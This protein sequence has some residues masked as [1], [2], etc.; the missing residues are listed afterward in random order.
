M[1]T[2]GTVN[3]SNETEKFNY[4]T[5]LFFGMNPEKRLWMLLMFYLAKERALRVIDNYQGH[6]DGGFS[7][8][9]FLHIDDITDNKVI[10]SWLD[11]G[12][13]N[14]A[15]IAEAPNHINFDELAYAI[16]VDSHNYM[17]NSVTC[18]HGIFAKNR[19]E[20]Q[21]LM[22]VADILISLSDDWYKEN[23]KW[24]FDALIRRIHNQYGK[25]SS[26]YTQP[27]ELTEIV[28]KI[29]SA[30]EGEVYNPYAGVC[31]Y[32]TI[33][34]DNCSYLGQEVFPISNAIGK[35]NLLVNDRKNAILEQCTGETYWRA[36]NHQFDYI[37][38]TP[39]FGL[40]IPESSYRTADLQFL[41]ESS[42]CTRH[43]SVGVYPA[44]ICNHRDPNKNEV[45]RRLIEEDILETVILLPSGVFPT[46]NIA[47]VL[48][49]VNK[50]KPN[51]G[52]VRFVDASGC[53]TKSGRYNILDVNSIVKK[54]EESFPMNDVAD[55][56]LDVLRSNSYRV[57]PQFY[58]SYIN[59][60]CPEGFK[61]VELSDV[62]TPIDTQ[63]I[64]DCESRIYKPNING[65]KPHGDIVKA[66][67]LPVEQIE[68]TAY[69]SVSEDAFIVRL[70]GVFHVSYLLAE[71]MSVAINRNYK[72]YSID[73]SHAYYQYILTE[74]SKEYFS[75]QL[76]KHSISGAISCIDEG[77]FL[78]LRIIIPNDY[79]EQIRLSCES[80]DSD[81]QAHINQ[82]SQKYQNKIDRVD[83]NQRQRKHAVAQ[84]L[85][86]ML[87]LVENVEDY[88]LENGAITKD[89]IV[90]HRFGT[91]FIE[92]IDSIHKQLNKVIDMVD[93]FTNKEEFGEAET[94]E[95]S[96]FLEEY[97]ETK[98]VNEVYRA[99]YIDHYEPEEI[100]QEVR[101]ARKDLT[102]ILDNLFTNAQKYG[103]I[104]PSRNDYEIRVSTEPIHDFNQPVV[105]KIA[106]NGVPVSESISLDKVFAWG[107][108]QGTGIGCWQ[109]K[110]IAEHFGGD[111]QYIEYPDDE[112]G[113]VCEF[114]I[115][116][117]LYA[118]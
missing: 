76:E 50:R 55:I 52:V 105:I 108:G 22:E 30:N 51:K 107:I 115:I 74:M 44:S 71:E 77:D 96:K 35:L 16:D 45:F 106:N 37:V 84:V 11:L 59:I 69:R 113:F 116:L 83:K 100:E 48:V 57:S 109:V 110:E 32:A 28:G 2:K 5:D 92:Y 72:P 27:K 40:R 82:L 23:T 8:M 62:L 7:L 18:Q 114:R 1:M 26:I 29:L 15:V 70:S 73:K 14:R 33:I 46:T 103:F 39:P 112:E 104:D 87:P 102:Q 58:T 85:N 86:Y 41:A 12:I 99:S 34:G 4:A 25:E 93:N 66:S 91:R 78:N 118:E 19:W 47:T 67:A 89:S 54:V 38:S 80:F 10:Q 75:R 63:R 117:P 21:Y 36:Y 88:V 13:N 56:S 79:E 81:I 31:S 53:K 90:S 9:A 6:A 98:R 95:L 3:F 24:A 111:A 64:E 49:V 94:I 42:R 68:R 97:C 60:S 65:S 17:Q 20:P 101:I 61:V 43:K